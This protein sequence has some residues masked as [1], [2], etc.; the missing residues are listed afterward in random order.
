M[1]I[2][3]LLAA[4]ILIAPLCSLAATIK[5]TIKFIDHKA[6]VQLE[7]YKTPFI[8]SANSNGIKKSINSLSSGDYI[9]GE[10]N[11]NIINQ[12]VKLVAIKYI[13]L[14]KILGAWRSPF[15][16]YFV[17][18]DFNTLNYYTTGATPTSLPPKL[19]KVIKYHISPNEVKKSWPII[20]TDNFSSGSGRIQVVNG[21]LSLTVFN[22]TGKKIRTI[23]L[24][25]VNKK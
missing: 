24:L 11:V 20:F 19:N 7:D 23:N 14:K 15:S 6:C 16:E 4:A 2:K 12:T 10:G 21:L 9:N 13:G 25:P 1:K 3:N 18:K 17:F 8:I 22:L 5:G